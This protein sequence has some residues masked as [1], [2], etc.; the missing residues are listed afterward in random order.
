MHQEDALKLLGW[1]LLV[2]F[3]LMEEVDI[4]KVVF[5]IS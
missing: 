1:K 2:D 4:I 5:N 3:T